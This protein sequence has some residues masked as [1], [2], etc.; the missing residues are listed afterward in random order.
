VFDDGAIVSKPGHGRYVKR[1][2]F[3]PAEPSRAQALA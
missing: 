1:S 3:E 2:L